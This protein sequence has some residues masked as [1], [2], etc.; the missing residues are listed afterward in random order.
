MSV[1]EAA[2]QEKGVRAQGLG[3]VG[4]RL[5]EVLCVDGMLGGLNSNY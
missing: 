2:S 3:Q 5:H 4:S 1:I